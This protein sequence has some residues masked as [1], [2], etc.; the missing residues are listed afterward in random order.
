[1]KTTLDL[2]DE[3]VRDM[4]L[5]S[6]SLFLLYLCNKPATGMQRVRQCPVLLLKRSFFNKG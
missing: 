1:M 5:R 4:K 6:V 3:L 2:P